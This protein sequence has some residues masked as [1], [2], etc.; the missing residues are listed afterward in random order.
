MFKH[1]LIPM[2]ALVLA[3]C[4]GRSP[5]SAGGVETEAPNARGQSPA[6]VGQTRIAEQKL[7]VVFTVETAAQGLEHPWGLAFLPDGRMLVT[8]RPGRLRYVARDGTLSA[9]I[10]G[11]P[12]VV[13]QGQAGLLDIALDPTFAANRRIY[14][15][16]VEPRPGGASVAIARAELD[17][18]KLANLTVIFRAEP[19][20]RPGTNY[21]SRLVFAPD[22]TLFASMG[23]RI[24][25]RAQDLSADNGK[26]IR[27]TT[28][29]A[30]APGNPFIGS[31]GARPDIWSIG[32]RNPQGMAINP[33]TGELW[34]I[35]HGARG[36]D[37][38]NIPRAGK[39]YGWPVITYGIDYTGL[40]IGR[41]ITAK[42]GMEQPLY[43]WDPVIA[44]SG[45]MFYTGEQFPAWKG[46]L[47]I[48]GMGAQA[49]VRVSLDGERITGEEH[50]LK[51]LAERI[52]EV[53]QGPDGLV[54]LLTDSAEG[55][56]LKLVPRLVK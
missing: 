42:A 4:G 43:Y 3:G 40:P 45:L 14:F 50:L 29:G 25:A 24:K 6:F 16:Y 22:G 47:F 49:L 20:S 36:G 34:N 8:E 28:D 38:I 54:Y 5:V 12:E 10:T 1:V 37:E 46:S 11:V 44:P 56:I 13:D 26:I 15:S 51:D 17:G 39:N 21:G 55:R 19:V 31:S 23:D 41:G 35:E 52:R 33:K 18:E 7:G 48:G 32:H 53:Q 30:P 9:P 2:A 27:I